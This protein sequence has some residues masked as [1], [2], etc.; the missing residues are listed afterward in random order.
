VYEKKPK[1][2]VDLKQNIRKEVAAISPNMLQ[3]V[4][5]NFQKLLGEDVDKGRHFTYTIFRK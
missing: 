1:T 5:Q 2:M 3:R 4:A